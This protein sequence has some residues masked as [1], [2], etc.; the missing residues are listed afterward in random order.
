MIPYQSSIIFIPSK[1]NQY[2]GEI[3][4]IID[5]AMRKAGLNSM[6]GAVAHEFAHIVAWKGPGNPAISDR[7]ADSIV[8]DR[9]LCGCLLEAKK[10]LEELRPKFV[11]KGY[12]SKDLQAFMTYPKNK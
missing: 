2:K 6:M 9:G 7:E 11:I 3:H 8:I 4:L 1:D 5:D 12:S 10:T